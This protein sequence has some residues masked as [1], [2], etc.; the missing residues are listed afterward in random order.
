MKLIVREFVNSVIEVQTKV[1]NILISAIDDYGKIPKTIGQMKG[2]LITFTSEGSPTRFGASN[3][4]DKYLM[5][6]PTSPTGLKW[7]NGGG[8][9]GGG[10]SALVTL[11]NNTGSTI[12][13]GT[14]LTIDENGD[15]LE[16]R[17]ATSSDASPLFIASDDY[18]TG[19]DIDCYAYPNCICNVLCSTDA[20]H[21]GD[22][23]CVSSSAGIANSGSYAT[24]GIA[25][26]EKASG[27]VGY[28]K[29]LLS[30]KYQYTIGNTDLIDGTSPLPSGHIYYYYEEE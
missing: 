5:S 16:V 13:A 25:L 6:D 17:K 1:Y 4:A 11:Y 19:G 10:G 2:D 27:A 3:I 22:P 18:P 28:S 8:G 26:T 12:L 20:V 23:I 7:G 30:G 29:V 21:I 15:E 14:V 24:I 9:G